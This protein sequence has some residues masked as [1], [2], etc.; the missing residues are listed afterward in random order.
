MQD[1]PIEPRVAVVIPCYRVKRHILGVLEAIGPE[2]AMIVAVDD[3]C[4]EQSGDFTRAHCTDPRLQVVVH[5]VNKGV[6]GAVMTGI[7]TAL[8]AGADIIVKIDGDGQMDPGLIGSFTDPIAA[9][10]ADYTKGNRFYNPE[11]VATMPTIRLLG[12]AGL[13]F[14][15]KL[16]SGYWNVFDPT[17]G[18]VA[19]DARLAALLPTDKIAQRYLFETDLLFRIGLLRAKVVDIPMRAVYADERSNLVVSREMPRFF[20]ANL[21]YFFKRVVYNYFL[22]DFNI[23]SLELVFGIALTLFGLVFG[24]A[25]WGTSAPATAGTVMIAAL[26]LLTGLLLLISFVNFDAQQI[27][28]DPISGRLRKARANLTSDHAA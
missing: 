7:A 13:S 28:R 21:T 1:T 25:N 12:N 22:R 11:D 5:P 23:A 6:G 26:P 20:A 9:G 4:P 18:Y 15:T 27:P 3:A 19:I 2:V 16:S 10:Q 14:L 8:A 24:L 17:N